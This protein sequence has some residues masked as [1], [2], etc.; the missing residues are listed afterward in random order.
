MVSV[1]WG[2]FNSVSAKNTYTVAIDRRERSRNDM[3]LDLLEPLTGRGYMHIQR[4]ADRR[5][6]EPNV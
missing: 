4:L 2:G 5:L 1:I 3:L 6:G